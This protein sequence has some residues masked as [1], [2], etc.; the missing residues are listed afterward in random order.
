M[1]ES[2][3]GVTPGETPE[4]SLV[5]GGLFYRLTRW[6][7]PTAGVPGHLGRGVTGIALFA[8]LPLL[9]LATLDGNALGE[10]IRVPFLLDAQVHVR[11]LVVLPLLLFAEFEVHRRI[12]PLLRQFTD[13]RLVPEHSKEQFETTVVSAMKL[14]NNVFAEVLLVCAVYGVGIFVIWRNYLALDT[15]TW[16]ATPSGERLSLTFAGMW[17]AFVSVPIVQFLLLRWYYRLFVWARLLWQV[18]RIDLQLVAAHPDRSGGLGFLA[19]TGYAFSILAG[20]HGALAA[21]YFASMIFFAEA[22]LTDFV[23]GICLTIMFVLFLILAPLLVF[24]PRLADVKQTELLKYEALADRYVRELDAKWLRGA[25]P[26][27]EALLGNADFQSLA[28]LASSY[29]VVQSM[30]F[31]PVTNRAIIRV[32]ATTLVP[33]APLL[34]TTISF[35]ELIKGVFGLVF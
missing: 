7:Y 9:M 30:R 22:S 5:E 21:G 27:N 34:L 23:A 6:L 13:R 15:A 32:A 11:L 33:I 17:Y 2:R 35:S 20:A 12:S 1:T 4:F 24:A 3:A 16:Y 14:R 8:W 28:D 18:S 31:S 26:A 29:A 25:M 19:S 10:G